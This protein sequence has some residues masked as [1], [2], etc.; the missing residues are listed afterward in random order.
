VGR[1]SQTDSDDDNH[2]DN[3]DDDDDDNNDDDDDDDNNDDD[4]DDDDDDISLD[5]LDCEILIFLWVLLD[6]SK[7]SLFHR[8][9]RDRTCSQ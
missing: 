7:W 9:I 3:N 6:W 8:L 1:S 4:D 5:E 2:D